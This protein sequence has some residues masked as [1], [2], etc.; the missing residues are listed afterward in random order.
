MSIDEDS[1][2]NFL[3]SPTSGDVEG[4]NPKTQ[5]LGHAE[6]GSPSRILFGG[7]G[8]GGGLIPTIRGLSRGT[9]AS[10]RIQQR[11]EKAF[12]IDSPI[13]PFGFSLSTPRFPNNP[14]TLSTKKIS[15]NDVTAFPP[16][17]PFKS[18]GTPTTSI[19]GKG[20]HSSA[21]R[22]SPKSRFE[23]DFTIRSIIGSGQFGSVYS[24][25][26]NF[27][28]MEYA[29]KKTKVTRTM[30][31]EELRTLARLTQDGCENIVRYFQG[32]VE[33]DSVYI[34]TELC[35]GTV[36]NLYQQNKFVNNEAEK[37]RLLRSMAEALTV[38]HEESLVHLDIKPENI[39]V[40]GNIYKLGDFGL[41]TNIENR[42]IVDDGDSRYM[43]PEILNDDYSDL[44]K[45]DIFSLG[46]TIL[47]L[48]RSPLPYSGE[49]WQSIRAGNIGAFD[50]GRDLHKIIL[51][52][53]AP[54]PGQR[55]GAASLR[56][57]RVLMTDK[58]RELQLEK[59]RVADLQ[60]RMDALR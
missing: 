16:Q 39:F 34:Q 24:V 57:M 50:A 29:V 47:E 32:W 59:N 55:P 23:S 54:A 44:K 51:S 11:L 52:M 46:C 22:A 43:S 26:Q 58:E 21:M 56:K 33:E 31:M 6:D 18:A 25:I 15:P 36:S 28:Q 35:E 17:T 8:F 7:G 45:A 60:G 9:A 41:A 53:L 5:E 48:C 40:R 30:K 42:R 14:P 3:G 20:P 27:D 13:T 19:L 2:S 4:G 38:I 10:P 37:C 12:D 1:C 49:E